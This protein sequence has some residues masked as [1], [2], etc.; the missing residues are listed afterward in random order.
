VSHGVAEAF[1]L[2][3]GAILL[4]LA[5]IW[6]RT[7]FALLEELQRYASRLSE[8][9]YTAPPPRGGSGPLRDLVHALASLG[10]QL[11]DVRATEKGQLEA[12]RRQAEAV[13]EAMPDPVLV[14]DGEARVA[15]FNSA[16]HQALGDKLAVGVAASELGSPVLTLAAEEASVGFPVGG[17]QMPQVRL[18]SL[19]EGA[20]PRIYRARAL[21]LS[22]TAAA[23]GAVLVLQDVTEAATEVDLVRQAALS[24]LV[25]IRPL[26]DA[27]GVIILG[28]RLKGPD[29]DATREDIEGYRE[30]MTVDRILR[31]LE[32]AGV[33]PAR[34]KID[35][36]K[37]TEAAVVAVGLEAQRHRVKLDMRIAVPAPQLV[38][39]SVAAE[40]LLLRTLRTALQLREPGEQLV[41]DVRDKPRPQV[42]IS[43]GFPKGMTPSAIDAALLERA[44][45]ALLNERGTAR[46]TT[47][48]QFTR[49]E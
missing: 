8:G 46:G 12:A 1:V 16:A 30:W 6:L 36:G 34:E 2:A 15:R 4:L 13:I 37:L 44:G 48:L 40:R 45:A 26:I 28:G 20:E 35:L 18:P 7:R 17:N 33:E 22:E 49:E 9:D 21:P 29:G 14:F 42:R 11:R 43:P 27:L 10:T 25:E 47:V 5:S 24:A 41:I 23:A 19:A 39:D 31:D 38:T 3:A 32:A